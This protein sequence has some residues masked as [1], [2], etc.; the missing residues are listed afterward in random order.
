M[1]PGYLLVFFFIVFLPVG[2]AKHWIFPQSSVNGVLVDYLMVDLWIQDLLA[3]SLIVYYF[4]LLWRKLKKLLPQILVFVFLIVL[5]VF[6]SYFSLLSAINLARFLL[7][8]FASLILR[9]LLEKEKGVTRV[10]LSGLLVANI[11]SGLLGLLQLVNQGSVFGWWF[12]GEPLYSAG[13]SGVKKVGN[14]VFSLG[15]FPHS[16]ILGAFGLISFLIFYKKKKQFRNK[17]VF[18]FPVLN[19]LLSFSLPTWFFWGCWLAAKLKRKRKLIAFSG[20]ICLA[21]FGIKFVN[22]SSFFR[23][24]Y[25]TKASW[26]IFKKSPFWGVGWGSFVSHLPKAST[27]LT[28]RFRFLQPVHNL[29]LIV[30]SEIGL[31]GSLGITG[32]V[33][34]LFSRVTVKRNKWLLFCFFFLSFFDHYFWTTTQVLCLAFLLAA[35]LDGEKE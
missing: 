3:L 20:I 24:Y 5:S 27:S 21:F 10:I 17:R 28:E 31:L 22:P 30:I 14:L 33:G 16:N 6:F 4:P 35:L 8:F 25:L 34:S 2:W 1:K 9:S 23:R 7:I 18:I 12:L 15:T 11:Y 32:L 26:L 29:F 13:S 19:I